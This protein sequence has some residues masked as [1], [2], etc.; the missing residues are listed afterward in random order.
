MALSGTKTQK[1]LS[2]TKEKTKQCVV[3]PEWLF[4]SIEAGKRLNEFKYNIIDQSQVQGQFNWE[5]GSLSCR[6]T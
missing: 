3:R 4:D 1:N 5:S 6:K 2:R